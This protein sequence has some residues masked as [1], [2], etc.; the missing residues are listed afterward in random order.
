MYLGVSYKKAGEKIQDINKEIKRNN[1]NTICRITSGGNNEKFKAV[2][3][4]LDDLKRNKT[5]N[6]FT[7]KILKLKKIFT[8]DYKKQDIYM[9]KDNFTKLLRESTE[10]DEKNLNPLLFD[11]LVEIEHNRKNPNLYCL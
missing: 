4:E 6:Y 9:D 5:K 2:F 10:L 1:S 11:K 8:T 3:F 7:R